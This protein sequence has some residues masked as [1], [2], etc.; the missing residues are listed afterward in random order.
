MYYAESLKKMHRLLSISSL[1]DL[2]IVDLLWGQV[3]LI[4]YINFFKMK[5]LKL[6]ALWKWTW[7]KIQLRWELFLVYSYILSFYYKKSTQLA[8]KKSQLDTMTYV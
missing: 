2:N 1:A 7:K 5:F 3:G 4:S 8:L 6:I